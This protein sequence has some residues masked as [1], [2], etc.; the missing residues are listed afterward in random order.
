MDASK[1]TLLPVTLP[2]DPV[3]LRIDEPLARQR[4]G[5]ITRLEGLLSPA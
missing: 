5:D 2:D 4:A 3:P 1:P